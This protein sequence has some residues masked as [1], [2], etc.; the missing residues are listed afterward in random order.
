MAVLDKFYT[1]KEVA[2]EC[3]AFLGKY[4][5]LDRHICLEP[6]AGNVRGGRGLDHRRV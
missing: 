4:V 1:K 6:S 3:V 5:D 2:K